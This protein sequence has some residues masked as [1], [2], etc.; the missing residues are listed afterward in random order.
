MGSW[1]ALSDYQPVTD[2]N[3]AV[4]CILQFCD[5]VL[6]KVDILTLTIESLSLSLFHSSILCFYFAPFTKGATSLCGTRK[7]ATL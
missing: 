2:V 5:S 3:S 6:G 7:T 1:T 4:K